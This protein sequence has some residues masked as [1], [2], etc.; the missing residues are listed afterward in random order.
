[1]SGDA[2]VLGTFRRPRDAALAIR[3]LHAGGFGDVR[4][5]MPAPF[6]EVVAA[7]GKPRSPVA[8][9]ALPGALLGLAGGLGLTVLT[10]LSWRLSTGGKPIVSMPPFIVIMFELGVLLGSLANLAAVAIGTW[11]GARRRSFPLHGQFTGERIGVFAAG[12]KGAATR[13]LHES[14]AE[15]VAD[16]A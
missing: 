7:I 13:I 11:R 2:G 14:G 6:P 9:V 12:D 4:V 8:F 5:A 1:M 10:S 3:A 15:E 16:V